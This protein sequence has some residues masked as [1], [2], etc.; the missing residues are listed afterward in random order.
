MKHSEI[1]FKILLTTKC[2]WANHGRSN[3][4]PQWRNW[5]KHLHHVWDNYNKHNGT[6]NLQTGQFLIW[7]ILYIEAM[8]CIGDTLNGNGDQNGT[9]DRDVIKKQWQKI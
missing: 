5:R 8:L 7:K 4:K 1:N 6:A 2:P 9:V 3:W